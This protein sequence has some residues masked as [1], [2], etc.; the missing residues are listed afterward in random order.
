MIW[1]HYAGI[2]S[3]SVQYRPLFTELMLNHKTITE[4]YLAK[5]F[6]T[7]KTFVVLYSLQSL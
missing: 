3:E 2:K 4:T 7:D 6:T 1:I 5:I